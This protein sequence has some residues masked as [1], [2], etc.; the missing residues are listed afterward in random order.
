LARETNPEEE[1]QATD[2]SPN[3]FTEGFTE[4]FTLL[5]GI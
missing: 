5:K 4:G 1:Q 3:G 2:G